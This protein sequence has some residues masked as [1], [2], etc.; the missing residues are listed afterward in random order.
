MSLII[1]LI[2]REGLCLDQDLKYDDGVQELQMLYA[3]EQI[4]ANQQAQVLALFTRCAK[5]P[6]RH[7]EPA[8]GKKAQQAKPRVP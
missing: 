1:I 8:P 6:R 5:A 2:K 4:P 7:R 3:G